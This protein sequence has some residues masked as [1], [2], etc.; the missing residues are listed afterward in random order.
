MQQRYSERKMRTRS[1]MQKNEA[2]F[3]YKI[4]ECDEQMAEVSE[5]VLCNGSFEAEPMECDDEPSLVR[6]T[7]PL[8]EHNVITGIIVNFRDL[9]NL[10]K[11]NTIEFEKFDTMEQ[12]Q[13]TYKQI[14]DVG[15][16]KDILFL[17]SSKQHFD[18]RSLHD[19]L[20]KFLCK[21]ETTYDVYYQVCIIT[22]PNVS[23]ATP[24][25]PTTAEISIVFKNLE[26]T[27]DE[28][29]VEFN[30]YT[31][32]SEILNEFAK[33]VGKKVN[34]IEFLRKHQ[35]DTLEALESSSVPLSRYLDLDQVYL[36]IHFQTC[37]F[38]GRCS[39]TFT[40]ITELKPKRNA[41]AKYTLHFKDRC[42]EL[43]DFELEF[44]HGDKLSKAFN[45]IIEML[46]SDKSS[47]HFYDS[48]GN[49]RN[50]DCLKRADFMLL[51]FFFGRQ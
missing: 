32:I 6:T 44:S 42:E 17:D 43:Q 48:N 10:D 47:C 7:P 29:T 19:P 40:S 24:K 46:S 2:I 12:V 30:K 28:I 51:F 13:D 4:I 31:K 5:S 38:A 49:E 22:A 8:L 15:V 1:Q 11:V 39:G 27:N 16:D 36:E 37:Q 35:D 26:A 33:R 41:K 45:E 3:G 23:N 9:N 50:E 25:T 18:D 21:D 34:E 14:L 20:D